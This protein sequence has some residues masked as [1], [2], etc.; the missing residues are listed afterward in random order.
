MKQKTQCY[1]YTYI[2]SLKMTKKT[3]D[4]VRYNI[5]IGIYALVG[6]IKNNFVS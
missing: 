5:Q 4:W 1:N 6:R 3:I 2:N